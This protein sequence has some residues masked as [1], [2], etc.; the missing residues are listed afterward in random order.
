MPHVRPEP[1]PPVSFAGTLLDP[2]RHVCAFVHN[3]AEAYKVLDPLVLDG[4]AQ[5]ETLSYIV[6]PDRRIDHVRHFRKLG[7]DM[8][9]LLTAGRFEIRTWAETHLAGG[10][11]DQDAMLRFADDMM[12]DRPYPRMRMV[13]V[14][15]WAEQLD[16]LTEL[17]EYEARANDIVARY[18]HVVIC[19]YDLT[20]FGGE[21]VIDALRTHPLV[22]IGGSRQVNPYFV[23]P[24]QLL[25]ELRA[26]G[27]R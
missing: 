25:G 11:F 10:T 2:H 26:Q 18:Q 13:S 15:G 9:R 19:V 20:R 17:V 22:L 27:R 5:G 24:A 23:P 12:R 8:P 4:I 21:V 6:D 3:A 1:R 16:D 7:L 14:M